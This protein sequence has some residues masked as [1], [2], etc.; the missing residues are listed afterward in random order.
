MKNAEAE[1]RERYAAVAPH[2]DERARRLILGAEANVLGRGGI[3]VVMRATGA[4]PNTVARGLAEVRSGVVL[5]EGR[6]RKAGAGRRKATE[7]DPTLLAD[8]DAMIEP[9]TRGDPECPLRWTSK[10]TRRLAEE[11]RAA[12]HQVTHHTVA[13][14]LT[15]LGYSL[16]ANAKVIEG[17]DHPDRDKQFEHVASEVQSFRD[18]GEPVISVDAKKK[19][20]V[21]NFKNAGREW[22]PEGE[23]ERVKVYD[24]V[25]ELGRA[26]PY[27]VYD[28]ARNEASVSVGTD[29]DTAEF[30]VH[31]IK[32]WWDTMG[33]AAYPDAKKLLIMADGG[34]SNSSRGRLWKFELQQFA[35]ATGLE[36]HVS[37]FPPGTSKWNK[38]E[39]RL[40]SFISQN[41][42]G[43]PLTSHEV[44][45]NLIAATTTRSGLSVQA[46]IDPR[47]YEK[48]RKITDAQM[49]ALQL[50]RNPF[51]GDW[52]YVLTPVTT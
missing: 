23:P 16:Q 18:E 21:G 39:H 35:D 7:N 50:T 26:T 17:G 44:I 33:L 22:M 47:T 3:A 14:L 6:I 20:L 15:S 19:E 41:W 40:F 24:F 37:H 28:I 38:I 8:L 48:G 11:L 32:T 49:K 27:G 45:V 12:G 29:H 30:A 1:I 51:H 34:G 5:P 25:E 2:V 4:S 43:R 52:N 13:R 31:S 36:V 9:A 42:R 46:A 10:S